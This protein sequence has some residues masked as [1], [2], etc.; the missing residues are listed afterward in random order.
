MLLYLRVVP[1]FL[2]PSLIAEGP[3]LFV[4]IDEERYEEV[5]NAR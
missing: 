2:G 4:A 1:L 5:L 3:K